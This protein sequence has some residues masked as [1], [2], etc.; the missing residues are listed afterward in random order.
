[1]CLCG[2]FVSVAVLFPKPQKQPEEKAAITIH[3]T[4][5]SLPLRQPLN[6]HQHRVQCARSHACISADFFSEGGRGE[7]REVRQGRGKGRGRGEE[8]LRI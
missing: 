3:M 7:R 5:A 8:A 1:M 2:V 6:T 4:S